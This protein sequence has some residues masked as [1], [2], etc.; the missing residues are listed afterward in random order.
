[1]SKRA[2]LWAGGIIVG[3][4][5]VMG[6]IGAIVSGD[7]SQKTSTPPQQ[8]Q[9][10][11]QQQPQPVAEKPQTSAQQQAQPVA[12]KPKANLEVT[13]SHIERGQFGNWYV[14]GTIKNNTN[15]QYRYVQ[16]DINLYDDAGNQIGATM[17]NT[18]NLEP[19]GTWKFKAIIPSYL[20]DSATKYKVMKITG[21]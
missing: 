2:L 5:V 4:L 1:M 12:E 6:V 21:R 8:Q 16:V 9:T 17:D 3:F 15:K 14:A 19:G 7:G 11:A 18:S 10:S 20:E 13:E